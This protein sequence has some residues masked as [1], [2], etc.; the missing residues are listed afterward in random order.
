MPVSS[1]KSL[2]SVIC[3]FCSFSNSFAEVTYGFT[4]LKKATVLQS[5]NRNSSLKEVPFGQ[6]VKFEYFPRKLHLK[7]TGLDDCC[8]QLLS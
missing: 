2:S 7:R 5:H 1:D 3:V 4:S 6:E 8:Q